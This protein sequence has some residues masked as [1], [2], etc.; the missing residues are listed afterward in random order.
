MSKRIAVLGLGQFGKVLATELAAHGCEVLAVD[1][2]AKEVEAVRDQVTVAAIADIRDKKALEELITSRFDVAVVAMGDALE[3]TVMATLHL[4]E[5]GVD[6][7]WTEANEPDRAEALK[8]VGATHVFAPEGDMARRVA[9]Q[10][11]HP[12]LIEFLP[13]MKG[14]GV[15]EI[16]APAWTHGKTLA[17]LDLRNTM[18]V[19]AIAIRSAEGVVDIVPGGAARLEPGAVLTLVGRDGDLAGFRDRK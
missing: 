3:A 18:S 19:A 8:K 2:S 5:L 15:A 7:V 6:E 14:Y 13:L 17:E 12:N 9:Q 4:K 1:S 11:A 10:L 16:E